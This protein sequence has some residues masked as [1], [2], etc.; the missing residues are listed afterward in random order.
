M[1]IGNIEVKEDGTVYAKFISPYISIFGPDGVIGRS[2][3]LHYK[4]IEYRKFPDVYAPP[5]YPSFDEPVNNET[6]EE[7][8]GPMIACGVI[9][10][11]KNVEFVSK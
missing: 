1:Q 3:V 7:M 10:Y 4:P 2:I 11:K 9:T 6:E 8:V 5:F